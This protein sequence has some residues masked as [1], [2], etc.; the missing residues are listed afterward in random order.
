M[1]R[2][3]RRPLIAATSTNNSISL[4]DL[5]SELQAQ[6]QRRGVSVAGMQRAGSLEVDFGMPQL[7]PGAD[8]DAST[9]QIERLEGPIVARLIERRNETR[10]SWFLDG[11]QKTLPVWRVGVV[12]IIVGVAVAAV[13]ARDENGECSL[14][15]ETLVE[16][17]TWFI[18]RDT[19]SRDLDAVIDVLEGAGEQVTDPLARF[20]TPEDRAQYEAFAGN[21]GR[22]LLHA[23]EAANRVRG[24]IEED[25]VPLWEATIRASREDRWMVVDGRLHGRYANAVGL[26]KDPT[27]QHLFGE[28]ASVLF[29]LPQGH[30][31][32]A[33]QLGSSRKSTDDDG[34]EL[35]NQAFTMWYQRMWPAQGLD[36]RHALIRLETS[37]DIWETEVID[38]IASW[39][40]AERIPR[41]TADARWATLL[42]P[43]HVLELMLKRRIKAMTTGWP[44]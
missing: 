4:P 19:G 29:N 26:V 14:V 7:P 16:Q 22:I 27:Q 44:S 3:S 17:R 15:G 21:Y 33:Y 39:L 12:P 35:R 25:I 31:T 10:F 1:P 9:L 23:Q 34:R 11:T 37:P 24:A 32:S 36:A 28:E 38:D 41:P 30:R 40:M 2:E 5:V 43:M 20:A 42:Y 18:P 6:L 13:L 8:D